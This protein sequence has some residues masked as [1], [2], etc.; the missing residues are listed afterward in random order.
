MF[1]P[2]ARSKALRLLARQITGII[3][4]PFAYHLSSP[5]RIWDSLCIGP[6]IGAESSV[7]EHYRYD[8][9][10]ETLKEDV[11]EV[12]SKMKKEEPMWFGG[13]KTCTLAEKICSGNILA[14][15]SRN[16]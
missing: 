5:L 8:M 12:L 15:A 16:F 1:S 9:H 14:F 7:L 2:S 3:S 11:E 13:Y 6:G 4:I 10:I